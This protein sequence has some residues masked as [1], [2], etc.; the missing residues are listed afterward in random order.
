MLHCFVCFLGSH[1]AICRIKTS[2]SLSDDK[3][4]LVHITSY[5][6]QFFNNEYDE[7]SHLKIMIRKFNTD[8]ITN[9]NYCNNSIRFST[10]HDKNGKIK[11]I[12]KVSNLILQ[13]KKNGSDYF[14]DFIS[15]KPFKTV[16]TANEVFYFHNSMFLIRKML[17]CLSE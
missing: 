14:R 17:L 2:N 11:N 12:D 7:S 6:K 15:A 1:I 4:T 13:L 10:Q 16:I 5:N 8:E 3:Y 9:N